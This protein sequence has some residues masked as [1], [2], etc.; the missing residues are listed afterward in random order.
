MFS[1]ARFDKG[2]LRKKL[3][4]RLAAAGHL[5]VKVEQNDGDDEDR[6]AYEDLHW[7][8][9]KASRLK[10]RHAALLLAEL[11]LLHALHFADRIFSSCFSLKKKSRVKKE[12]AG[13]LYSLTKKADNSS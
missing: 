10:L 13:L 1:F 6:S 9:L 5:S 11:S 12:D 8:D 2:H 4:F 7:G 3:L